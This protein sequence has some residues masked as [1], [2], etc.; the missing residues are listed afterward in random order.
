MYPLGGD[1][2][3]SAALPGTSAG[4]AGNRAPHGVVAGSRPASVKAGGRGRR[5]SLEGVGGAG[6]ALHRVL[7]C[8]GLGPDRVD[9]DG[10]SLPGE[11]RR[12]T[13]TG[14]AARSLLGG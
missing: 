12:S 7:G 14:R 6:A 10:Y 8:G 11:L 4:A 9:H 13:S 3:G 1:G 5:T 2:G